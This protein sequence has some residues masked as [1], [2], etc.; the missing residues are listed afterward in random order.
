MKWLWSEVLALFWLASLPLL[1]GSLNGTLNVSVVV[2]GNSCTMNIPPLNFGTYDPTGA[3][4]ITPLNQQVVGTVQCNSNLFASLSL[5]NGLYPS[6]VSGTTRAMSDGKGD[7]LGYEIYSDASRLK[8]LSLLD[9]VHMQIPANQ[10]APFTLYGSIPP[11]QLVP[12]GS[13]SDTLTATLSF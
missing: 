1:A 8:I 7:Y 6:R 9:P 13:Y 12:A 11:A 3:Q 2:V 4:A 10:P 5:D